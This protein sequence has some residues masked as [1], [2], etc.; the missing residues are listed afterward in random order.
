MPGGPA[1]TLWYLAPGLAHQLGNALFTLQGRARLLASAEPLQVGEDCRAIQDGVER[2]Q[3]GLNMLR[4]LLDE[5]RSS[6]VPI[7]SLLHSLVEVA[8]VPLRDRGL[9]LELDE[10][11]DTPPALVDPGPVCQLVSAACR[12][13][14][15]NLPGMPQGRMA[16][17]FRVAGGEIRLS[18]HLRPSTG[19]LPFPR[20]PA[21]AAE[22]L[23]AELAAARAHWEGGGDDEALAL[24]LPI[25]KATFR[26]S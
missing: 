9:V 12:V 14:A 18:F 21:H 3:A 17:G 6:P 15:A 5:T 7:A 4:W 1:Q 2:A 23:H 22:A 11:A 24:L 16:I 13:L 20:D 25:A 8:R 26:G 19:A 10:A